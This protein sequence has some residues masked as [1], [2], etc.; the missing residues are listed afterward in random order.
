ME[1]EAPLRGVL[2]GTVV[3]PSV[4][5]TALMSPRIQKINYYHD[6]FIPPFYAL[7]GI[8]HPSHPTHSIV[9]YIDVKRMA[10]KTACGGG[11]RFL[12]ERIKGGEKKIVS[13]M[14]EKINT[15]QLNIISCKSCVRTD[16][17]LPGLSMTL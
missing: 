8:I 15:Y 12:E 7:P 9:I 11:M 10:R 2:A 14:S 4:M 1:E 16:A 6:F 13:P 17:P 3:A 5:P